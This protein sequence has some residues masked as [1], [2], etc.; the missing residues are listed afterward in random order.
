MLQDFCCKRLAMTVVLA[1]LIGSAI[2]SCSGQ[3]KSV[4]QQV[5]PQLELK[6]T[7]SSNAQIVIY[8]RARSK[9]LPPFSLNIRK[10]VLNGQE[11]R[12]YELSSARINLRSDDLIR[13]QKL[14]LIADTQGGKYSGITL[15]IENVDKAKEG[16]QP[17]VITIDHPISIL[18]G[19]SKTIF[20]LISEASQQEPKKVPNLEF[21][22]EDEQQAPIERLVY[23]ANEGSS[24]ISVVSKRGGRV[25]YNILVGTQPY[26]LAA[27]NRRNRLYIADRRES[28]VYELDMN[29]QHLVKA[30]QFGFT[31]EPIHIL[32]IPQRDMVVLVNYGSDQVYLLDAFTLGINRTVNVGDGPIDAVYSPSYDRLFVLN[33]RFGTMSVIDLSSDSEQPETTLV[34]EMEPTAIA[35]DEN[36][37]WLYITNSGSTNLTVMRISNLGVEKT[38]SVG[39]GATCIAFDP[40]GRRIYIGSKATNEILCIDPYTGILV[41]TIGLGAA[42]GRLLFDSDE[43]RLYATVPD[44]NGIAVIDPLRRE[45]ENWVETGFKPRAMAFRL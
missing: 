23:V 37:D 42:P 34:L 17:S 8:A 3:R 5:K 6:P 25:V 11:G 24:N 1:I 39:L 33:Q 13:H 12:Q 18:A 19:S 16:P 10:I 44:Q 27:D 36:M 38:I 32:P 2:A 43:R 28:V 14:V 22:I 7:G 4:D 40:Y 29:T 26:A 21:A 30:N 35:I 41:Y 31:D 9:D 20:V 15:F 45:I